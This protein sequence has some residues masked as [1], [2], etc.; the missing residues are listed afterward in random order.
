MPRL[1]TVAEMAALLRVSTMTIYRLINAGELRTIRI[2]RSIRIPN[3]VANE[4]LAQLNSP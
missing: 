2:G 1:L 4:Y 3:D